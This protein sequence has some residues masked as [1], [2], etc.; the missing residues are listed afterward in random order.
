MSPTPA[1]RAGGARRHAP[2]PRAHRGSALALL[3]Q[4]PVRPPRETVGSEPLRG[5]YHD[6]ASPLPSARSHPGVSPA[7]ELPHTPLPVLD[8]PYPHSPRGPLMIFFSPGAE[9]PLRA[10]YIIFV[11]RRGSH[12]R[13]GL[14]DGHIPFQ[15]PPSPTH[16]SGGMSL[17][18]GPVPEHPGSIEDPGR[19]TKTTHRRT[20]AELQE[21]HQGP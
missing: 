12:R 10:A 6:T 8:L 3:H 9:L 13:Q 15:V 21:R 4:I 17:R 20:T 5:M 16:N 2:F 1:A 14:R 11:D 7:S 18:E 19:S